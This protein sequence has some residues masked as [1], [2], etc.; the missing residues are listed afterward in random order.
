MKNDHLPLLQA[1]RGRSKPKTD[2]VQPIEMPRAFEIQH[3]EIPGL[4]GKKVGD[5]ISVNL[6]GHIHS[7]NNDGHAVMHVS[8][9]KPDSTEMTDKANPGR[10]TPSM[11]GAAVTT[12]ESHAP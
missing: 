6:A 12:Q 11:T 9:V 4:P 5:H 7:Q 10:K 1:L 3:H 8:S 2:S